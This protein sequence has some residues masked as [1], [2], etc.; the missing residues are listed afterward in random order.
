MSKVC[1]NSIRFTKLKKQIIKWSG[2]TFNPIS[3]SCFQLM[4][5]FNSTSKQEV[6]NKALDAKNTKLVSILSI[7]CLM[8]TKSRQN[9]YLLAIRVLCRV[10]QTREKACVFGCA[11]FGTLNFREFK[12]ALDPT[13][14][15][16]VN[17]AK[18]CVLSCLSKVD[19]IKKFHSAVFEL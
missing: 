19:N 7:T 9:E 11:T 1:I 6:Q 2:F 3:T 5:V 15:T 17:F 4:F 18:S 13:Y 8:K 16:L 12:V 10:P 14:R